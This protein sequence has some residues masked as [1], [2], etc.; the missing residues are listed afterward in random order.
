MVEITRSKAI[1][2]DKNNKTGI[3]FKDVKGMEEAKDQ[4]KDIVNYFKYPKKYKK[5]GAVP[6][7]G[8]ILIGAPGTGKTFLAKA[9]AGESDIAFLSTNG[10]DFTSMYMG[11]S[12]ARI[13]NLF[14]KARKLKKAIIFI[15]E[16]DTIGRKRRTMSH[17]SHEDGDGALNQLLYELDGFE[18]DAQIFVIGATNRVEMLD[19]A[20]LRSGRLEM[21]V[22]TNYPAK[23]ER[24]GTFDYY[25]KKIKTENNVSTQ[26][27]AVR[28]PGFSYADI[29]NVVNSA[30][31]IAINNKRKKVTINDFHQ[32]IDENIA[33]IKRKVKIL[34]PKE[35]NIVAYH[36]AGHAIVGHFLPRLSKIVK[37]TIIPRTSSAL[38]FAQYEAQEKQLHSKNYLLDQI[39]SLLGGR[40]SEAIFLKEISTGAQN[41]LEKVT[42]IAHNLI[43]V[44]GMNKKIG[45]ISY[46][47]RKNP[48]QYDFT[49]ICSEK[50][51][52]LINEEIDKIITQQYQ[53]AVDIIKKHQD[54]IE[55][56][57]ATL[58][59]KEEINGDQ[60]RKLVG[61][62]P[63]LATEQK[64]TKTNKK[65]PKASP[66]ATPPVKKQK[67]PKAKPPAK[68]QKA[69][70][71][72]KSDNISS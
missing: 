2:W 32:A 57:V 61:P 15:D 1:L 12:T 69:P 47:H 11:G 48:Q 10:S 33:G 35:K 72:V 42:E 37:V 26:T 17:H 22:Y 4:V 31:L 21:K 64:I 41:D 44:Y 38:G 9:I 20:L 71:K 24:E 66:K 7:K 34:K 3:T 27:L 49:R 30:A 25:L 67:T 62:R 13:R 52:Q 46:Y 58:K 6:P 68:K 65:T 19:N 29:K 14:K 63:T 8:A 53:R 36:E 60:F 23:T 70:K 5:I 40:A 59:D 16:I 50:R 54:K 55:K 28:T 39:C 18:S 43:I 51:L 56:V 45:H